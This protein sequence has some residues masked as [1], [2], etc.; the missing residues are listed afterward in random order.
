MNGAFR[1]AWKNLS[2]TD[3]DVATAMSI[4]YEERSVLDLSRLLNKI[5]MPPPAGESRFTHADTE[6]I[7]HRLYAENVL[8]KQSDHGWRINPEISEA[9]MRHAGRRPDFTVLLNEIR[10]ELPYKTYW[11]PA[12]PHA[13]MREIRIAFYQQNESGFDRLQRE[14]EN[15]Y[16]DQARTGIFIDP[17]FAEFD[18][19]W[20]E[21]LVPAWQEI[22]LR[23][24]FRR[25]LVTMESLDPLIEF[26][27]QHEHIREP[28]SGPLRELL[29]E[30]FVLQGAWSRLQLW[31]DLETS[32]W[33]SAA[34][35]LIYH[36]LRDD[37]EAAQELI[38]DVRKGYRREYEN[39][40]PAHLAGYLYLL[41]LLRNGGVKS[42]EAI[43]YHLDNLD[44]VQ[45]LRLGGT[46]LVFKALH[47]YLRNDEEAQEAARAGLDRMEAN[48]FAHTFLALYRLWTDGNTAIRSAHYL[49]ELEQLREKAQD[50]GYKWVEMEVTRV[51][52]LRHPEADAREAYAGRAQQLSDQ[53]R[54]FS[55]ADAMPRIEPWER[56]LEVLVGMGTPD[57]NNGKRTKKTSRFVWFVD[58]E[59]RDLEPREQTLSKGGSWSK[60]RKVAL[61]RV[62]QGDVEGMTPQDVSVA[63]AIEED[64]SKYHP[65][66]SYTINY[67]D[68]LLALVGHPNL[69]L[70]KNPA[71]GVELIRRNPQL[72][73][74]ETNNRLHLRFAQD[75]N[76]T[77]VQVVKETPT[78]YQV[79]E[80]NDGHSQIHR[81]I[82]QGLEIPKRA[83]HRLLEVARNLSKFTEVQNTLTGVIDDLD[84]TKADSRT[85]V[86][87]LPVG[88]TFKVEFFVR[89]IF[90][91]DQYFKPGRGRNKV[92]SETDGHRRLAERDLSREIERAEGVIV[93][94]PTLQK[95]V[96]RDYEWQIDEV[97]DCLNV[98]LELQPLR[99]LDRIVLEHPRGEKIK[100]VG[101][102]DF[103]DLSLGVKEKAGWFDVEGTL[104]V[105]EQQMLTF[106]EL[107]DKVSE[108]EQSNFIQISEGQYVALTEQ[109]RR[110]LRE[111]EGLM[112]KN[113]DGMQLHPLASGLLDDVADQLGAFET[114]IAWRE[115]LERIQTV[116]LTMA[117]VPSTFRAE[118]RPY[119]LDGFRWLMRLADWGV[120]AC[121]A[122]D[123]G[124]GKTVQALAMLQARAEEGPALVIAPA[125]V[126]RNWMRE[127]AKFAPTLN[128]ILLVGSDRQE[129]IDNVGPYDMLVVSYGL[130]P[131]E[132]DALAEKRFGTIVL[133]EA[134]AI[135][136][137]G[138]KR[139]QIAM[140]LQGDF[141]VATTGTPIENHLGELWNLFTFLNPGLLGTFQ[142]FNEKYTIPVTRNNDN[143]RRQQ[144]RRLI[145]P[146][147]LRRR[148]EE[149]LEELPP[150]TEVTLTV[151]LSAAERA[152]Y[153]ALR[154]RALES[155]D[156][157]EGPNRRFQILAELMKLRQA[158]C[159]PKLVDPDVDIESSKLELLAETVQELREGGH[160]ALIFSQFVRHL[161]IV[162]QWA[163]ANNVPYQYLDGSTP[164][165]KRDEAVQAFQ[166]GE[167]DIFLISLK[168]GGTG[169]TLT[170]AD[171]VLH[172]DP[173]WNPAVEDQ[174]SDRAHR[175]GQQ[176]PVTV[177]RFVSENTIEE[178]IVK[179]HAEK[180]D[181]ADS[182]LAG[183]EQ[184]A[185]LS[186][187]D[188]LDL[189]KHG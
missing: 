100:L 139:S 42:A 86:H 168:A 58:F 131:F 111:M 141:R 102:V 57:R 46:Y 113:G 47:A 149:V 67:E 121:L 39:K 59:N 101:S 48:A 53:L 172:L 95:I 65:N 112:S 84:E 75:F 21:T 143:E 31:A 89:P 137:R 54:I 60:G 144:L 182:L 173:W 56:A 6:D 19:R 178:K 63:K 73:I 175:I 108:N 88:E 115:S 185:S 189:I 98:L 68:A 119:Q 94:C 153:E 114:D 169:L 176:R 20:V 128:P 13:L 32:E 29:A 91:E 71:I 107:I 3:R 164:G 74:E 159:H 41:S 51:L 177:Y 132:G 87:L 28:E 93:D 170:A 34:N 77:G 15:F 82:G 136:N 179:L 124:L 69:Y 35:Y 165:P 155:I 140:K 52:S 66:G 1:A 122:D 126:T 8:V 152:F 92:I 79:I 78:R 171:Y 14:S 4:V 27:E 148:K 61:K 24:A 103:G 163:I 151:E 104:A 188:L 187:D 80:V 158:A 11:Q 99:A 49:E 81:Q 125:S 162:E 12:S 45:N 76:G 174:A 157:S 109:L 44:P 23:K 97:E 161:K 129:I 116:N 150:K 43:G 83:R 55:L 184:S 70:T 16:P 147:I 146:F 142:R 25:A 50:N 5:G 156:D 2:A 120:G 37:D 90:E 127:A 123:M 180:R 17:L 40:Y 26:L 154:Q 10:R 117:R 110:K 186:A 130:L 145:Q 183:T 18:P 160:K 9:I 133:D 33:R 22:N 30:A 85:Y 38:D 96:H 7:V 167:G 138:T 64:Y 36:V 166:R 118:L 134:Q 106:R 135:K 72:L 105:D 181:L 62:K